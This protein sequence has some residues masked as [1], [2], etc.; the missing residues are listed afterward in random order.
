[1]YDSSVVVYPYVFIFYSPGAGHMLV[2]IIFL[3]THAAFMI[4]KRSAPFIMRI[5]V[6]QTFYRANGAIW[7]SERPCD[8][9]DGH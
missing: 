1:M 9:P 4:F 6:M 7:F 5:G 8:T 3:V 2:F